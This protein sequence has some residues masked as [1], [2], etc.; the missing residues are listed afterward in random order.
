MRNHN[1]GVV[2]RLVSAGA[3]GALV[4]GA[5]TMAVAPAYAADGNLRGAVVDPKGN[6]V[7]GLAYIYD[8]AGAQIGSTYANAGRIEATI[9]TSGDFRVKFVPDDRA[10]QTE[11]YLDQSVLDSANPITS[12]AGVVQM[13]PWTVNYAPFVSGVV[14]D[15]AGGPIRNATV[16]VFEAAAEN[17]LRSVYTDEDGVFRTAPG[18]SSP[19]KVKISANS[20]GSNFAS[21][22][23]NDQPTF[24]A[25]TAVTPTAEGG[26]LGTIVLTQGAKISGVVTSDAG[27]PIELVSIEATNVSSGDSSFDQTDASGAYTVEGLKPG[28]YRI[29][30]SDGLDEYIGEYFDNT[31]EQVNAA[32]VTV[33]MD[34][35]VG[36]INMSLAPKPVEPKTGVDISG[37]VVDETG[38]PLVGVSVEAS[39]TPADAKDVKRVQAT[40]TNRKG[41]Y[42][43]DKIDGVADDAV[44]V[45]A[46]GFLPREKDT[47]GVQGAWFG[48]VQ[49]SDA[50]TPIATNALPR[51]G[52]DIRLVT[53]G[54]IS[55]AVT[56]DTGT[57]LKGVSVSVEDADGNKVW[58]EDL[59]V[60]TDGT[61]KT[62][63][64]EPGNYFVSFGA[65]DHLAESWNDTVRAKATLVVVTSAK[66]TTGINAVLIKSLVAVDRPTVAG[67]TLVGSTLTAAPGTW[68][69]M[70]GAT[71][72]YEWLANGVA[73][74][75]GP[76]L[77]LTSAHFGKTIAVRVT[78]QVEAA[79]TVFRGTA[80][81]DS[82]KVVQAKTDTKAKVKIKKGKKAKNSK[83]KIVVSAG[84]VPAAMINGTVAIKLAK[85]KKKMVKVGSVK[86]KNGKASVKVSEIMKNKKLRKQLRKMGAKKAKRAKLVLVFSG[87]NFVESQAVVKV[88][89]L[90]KKGGK[91]GGRN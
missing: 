15:S 4:A 68:N 34:Q 47:F 73:V 33:A 84:D 55:G 76:S 1:G 51:T 2:R 41:V 21:E 19:V 6:P 82:T 14:T 88:K 67:E 63:S 10:L 12:G 71:Y 17:E 25:A 57:P 22:W 39:T 86:V 23:F 20:S 79:K 29:R 44:K 64:L 87:S 3:A 38:K 59:L 80:V 36:G 11:F 90:K 31:Q 65:K 78:S 37:T 53:N 69:L 50:A 75:T 83:V 85:T 30:A 77:L 74:S 89:K 52:A 46:K 70:A 81:S 58:T 24:A 91:K 60:K 8:A 28:T 56:S 7:S 62:Q 43:L 61:Y 66:V 72:S 16:Q 13:S 5:L 9:P 35:T 18:T 42:Q 49:A 27:G 48:N 26:G 32:P 54:G 40:A 45:Y